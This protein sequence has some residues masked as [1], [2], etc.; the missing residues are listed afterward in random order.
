MPQLHKTEPKSQHKWIV[1]QRLQDI[2]IQINLNVIGQKRILKS[3]LLGIKFEK[4]QG[5]QIIDPNDMV[6]F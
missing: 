2:F 5:K 6:V 3:I 4:C 1:F